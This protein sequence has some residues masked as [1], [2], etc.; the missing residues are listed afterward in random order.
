MTD[1]VQIMGS[2]L[3]MYSLLRE[4]Y[5]ISILRDDGS[6]DEEKLTQLAAR[7]AKMGANA[8]RDFYWIDTEEAYRKISPFWPDGDSYRF[9]DRYFQHQRVIA[10][11]CNQC[12]MR[13]YLSIFD[14]CGVKI[15]RKS[16]VGKF[17]PWRSFSNFFYG[18]DARELRHQFI[19][20]V[21][22][23]FAGRDVG[24]ELCNEPDK[25]HGDFLADTFIHIFKKGFDPRKIILGIDYHLKEKD[26]DYGNDYRDMRKKAA[27]ELGG[28]WE[29]DLKSVCIS[30]V[31]NASADQID[32]LWG[33]NVGPGGSRRILYSMDGVRKFEMNNET[34]D[35]RPDKA[36][37]RFIAKKVLEKKPEAREKDKVHFE[38]VFGKDKNEPLDSIEGVSEAYREIWGQYP[39]NY[40]K[41]IEGRSPYRTYVTHGYRGLLGREPDE[42]GMQGYVDFLKGGGDILEFCRK[43]VAS[44]E[45]KNKSAN[46][47]PQD[48][49]S[50]L[51][52]GILGRGADMGGL[53]HTIAE[54]H[55]G[56]IAE[57]AE[58]MLES[59]EFDSKFL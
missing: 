53:K 12:N 11:T 44:D 24:I 36:Y 34:K 54:I 58:A 45:F 10:E 2:P 43:L 1:K 56:R 33:P 16:E 18:A 41:D 13:Y 49:A 32:E 19:D 3:G 4:P 21:L 27:A 7:I 51:Y 26:K 48:L 29:Q 37:M 42:D 31:H 55:H 38:I 14:H 17:N 59:D 9:N 8:L 23:A 6:L 20:R 30:P 46:L 22:D 5:I 39:G 52:K 50:G 25:G 47:P 28:N 15:S 57:R 35:H 40:G